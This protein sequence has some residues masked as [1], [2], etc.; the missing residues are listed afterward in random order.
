MRLKTF[1]EA[2]ELYMAGLIR[3]INVTENT[4][5]FIVNNFEG[6]EHQV[7]VSNK[8]FLKV[9]C[10]CEYNSIKGEALGGMCKHKLA[11]IREL[12]RL[13]GWVKPN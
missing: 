5:L 12:F 3:C 7:Y 9:L 1:K 13:Q 10:D 6:E 2:N 4:A 11:V 8:G